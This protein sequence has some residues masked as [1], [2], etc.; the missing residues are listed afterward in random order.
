MSAF[1]AS[2]EAD[3]TILFGQPAGILRVSAKG[4]EPQVVIPVGEGERVHGPHL[5]PDGDTVLFSSTTT[6]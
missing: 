2:W 4:G 6:D 1:G 3:D 5:L